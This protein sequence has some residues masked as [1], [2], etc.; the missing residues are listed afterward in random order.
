MTESF[1]FPL[2]LP[3][4]KSSGLPYSCGCVGTKYGGSV[5]TA[6]TSYRNRRAR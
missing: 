1:C 2:T 6:A 3:Q 4:A 5:T